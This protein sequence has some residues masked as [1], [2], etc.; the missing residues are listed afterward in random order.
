MKGWKTFAFAALIAVI[1]ALSTEDVRQF[2]GA[3]LPWLGPIMG[4][5]VALLRALTNTPIFSAVLK[6]PPPAA[7]FAFAL[8][9]SLLLAGCGDTGSPAAQIDT[10]MKRWAVAQEAHTGASD[11]LVAAINAGVVTRQQAVAA[12]QSLDR[13]QVL[14]NTALRRMAAG[15]DIT[16]VD[17]LE[18]ATAII[19]TIMEEMQRD[20]TGNNDVNPGAYRGGVGANVYRLAY[21][22]YFGNGDSRGARHFARGSGRH[23]GPFGGRLAEA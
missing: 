17:L 21:L 2:V 11:L 6:K 18:S 3:N 12:D 13:A 9:G 20:T 15:D 4:A 14:L 8:T 7:L 23:Q 22:W 10:P 1:G 19:D 5:V 16:A